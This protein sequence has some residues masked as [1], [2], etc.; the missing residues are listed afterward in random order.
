[1]AASD[2]AE[3]NQFIEDPALLPA[4]L[5]TLREDLNLRK[6]FGFTIQDERL[7]LPWEY[8]YNRR[9]N[10]H[11]LN[12]LSQDGTMTLAAHFNRVEI[13]YLEPVIVEGGSDE[14]GSDDDDE[15][16]DH[17][18]YEQYKQQHNTLC[19]LRHNFQRLEELFLLQ[20][21]GEENAATI[22]DIAPDAGPIMPSNV[23][24]HHLA[25]RL[26]SQVQQQKGALLGDFHGGKW[27]IAPPESNILL[28]S[29]CLLYTS[30]SP[31]DTR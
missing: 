16:N 17:D 1:M 19:E 15:N 7:H 6:F 12:T 24:I 13:K 22:P 31:R 10:D 21:E 28:Y 20:T 26:I 30:P 2:A 11:T 5:K 27:W 18:P 23:G 29:V 4:D 25:Y 14:G 3:G 9:V 8:P